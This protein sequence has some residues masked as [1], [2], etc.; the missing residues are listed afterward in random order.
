MSQPDKQT[1]AVWFSSGAA[2]AVAAKRT[3]EEYGETHIIRVINNPVAEEDADNFRFLKDVEA[4]I[5]IPI[6]FA[7]N[8]KYP[9]G[10]AVEVWDKKKY[11][12]GVAG[13]PCTVELKKKARQEWESKNR[14][15]WHV[16]GFTADEKPRHDRFVLTERE[17][18]IP[19]LIDDGITKAECFSILR[20]AGIKLPRIYEMGYPNANCIGCVKATSP[21]YWS[22]VKKMHPEIFLARAEQS[23]RIGARLVRYK[24]VRIFLDELPDGAQ[25][26]PMNNMN[27]E[28]GI[29][30]EEKG[31]A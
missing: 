1:I 8:S 16:L 19:I 10:S 29:F 28:C 15:D 25:G 14:A 18:V 13:A 27:F 9:T 12:G 17:N 23:R 21:T 26:K 20:D 24:N 11:M 6:E 7:L 3:V 22:H 31:G 5:G 2:S 4:W 30:C